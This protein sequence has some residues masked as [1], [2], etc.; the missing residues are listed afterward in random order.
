MPH[1]K[2]AKRH[3]SI[4]ALLLFLFPIVASSQAGPCTLSYNALP[5]APELKGFYLGMTMAQAKAHVPQIVFGR[6]DPLGITKTTIN[7]RFDPRTD[8]PQFQ[9]VRSISLE[10]LD[11]RLTSLWFGYDASFKWR[12]VADFVTGISNS[13]ALPNAW[14]DWKLRGKQM[15]CRDFDLTVSIIAQAPSFRIVDR[16]AAE[17]FAQRREAAAE[18][19]AAAETETEAESEEFVG[20]STR[21]IYYLPTCQPA[22]EISEENRVVFKS[23]SEAD[24]AGYKRAKGC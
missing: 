7:P 1:I 24:K 20:D 8:K 10:F 14:R 19:E 18:A 9:D 22:I 21:K 16:R 23:A 12:S 11:A 4:A 15:S 3:F 13:L 2:F 5:A 17:T 6:T